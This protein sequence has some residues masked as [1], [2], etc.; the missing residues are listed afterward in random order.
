MM[1]KGRMKQHLWVYPLA[2][3]A[4][5]AEPAFVNV[6]GKESNWVQTC[7]GAGFSVLLRL[8]GPKRPSFDKPR[9]PGEIAEVQ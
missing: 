7:L 5:P 3:A 8:Y 1:K 9:R 2:Q 4:N 6:F